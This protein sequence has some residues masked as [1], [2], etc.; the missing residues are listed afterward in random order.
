M[1][2]RVRRDVRL[3]ARV[4]SISW[5]AD[6]GIARSTKRH[7]HCSRFGAFPRRWIEQNALLASMS[8]MGQERTSGRL[9]LEV[10]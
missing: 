3:D 1:R 7:D 4:G 5:S 6:F 9:T 2:R 10:R 8:G